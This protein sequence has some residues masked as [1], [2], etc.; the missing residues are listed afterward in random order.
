MSNKIFKPFLYFCFLFSSLTAKDSRPLY[1]QDYRR[2]V[3]EIHKEEKKLQLKKV[4]AI[5]NY[6]ENSRLAE[7]KN[8]LSQF[9]NKDGYIW[10]DHSSHPLTY[11]LSNDYSCSVKVG[12]VKYKCAEAAFQAYKFTDN[13]SLFN[14]FKKMDGKEALAYGEKNNFQQVK[15]WYHI[16]ETIMLAVLKAKFEQHADLKELLLATGDAYLV[17]HSKKDAF[18]SD[19]KDGTG[20]NRLGHLLMQVR[21]ELGGIGVVPKPSR[22]RQFVK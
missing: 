15:N 19:R 21:G 22:Y 3:K 14:R 17:E 7:Q 10:F 12:N 18:W 2:Q 5:R 4:A 16:R 1:D 6:K 13:P 20:K 11:F 9:A 8:K